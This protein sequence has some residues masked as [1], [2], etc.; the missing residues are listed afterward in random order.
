MKSIDEKTAR[1]LAKPKTGDIV[2]RNGHSATI[3]CIRPSCLDHDRLLTI[4][5][6]EGKTK[7]SKYEILKFYEWASMASNTIR[8]GAVLIPAK[9]KRG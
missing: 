6:K 4:K 8:H 1:L 2:K 9:G 7:K 3:V 5:Y